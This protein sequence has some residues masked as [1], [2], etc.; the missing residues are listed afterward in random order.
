MRAP[1]LPEMVGGCNDESSRLKVRKAAELATAMAHAGDVEAMAHMPGG[2]FDAHEMA[3]AFEFQGDRSHD[4][5]RGRCARDLGRLV[6]VLRCTPEALSVL[7][8]QSCLL[9]QKPLCSSCM[10]ACTFCVWREWPVTI[11]IREGRGRS[12]LHLEGEG[13][14]VH[15]AGRPPAMEGATISQTCCSVLPRAL[16]QIR[17]CCMCWYQAACSCMCWCLSCMCWYQAA[18][19]LNAVVE[20]LVGARAACWLTFC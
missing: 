20:C 1:P 5:V 10:L 14:L 17:C 3:R 7:L 19:S 18:C 11:P 15:S 8:T 12:A 9:S 2:M 4:Q 6:R 16:R 13:N